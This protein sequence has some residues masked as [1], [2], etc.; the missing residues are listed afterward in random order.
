[1]P[2]R[3]LFALT[4]GLI[5]A[6]I[7][8]GLVVRG[9]SVQAYN[10]HNLI[11]FHIIPNSNAEADQVLKLRVRDAVVRYLTPEVQD[12]QDAREARRIVLRELD[13]IRTVA[14]SEVRAA[15]KDYP[16]QVCFGTYHFP[17]RTYGA[18]QV[19]EGEYQAVRVVIGAGEGRNWWCVLFPPLC[20]MTV[21]ENRTA[22]LAANGEAV[23]VWSESEVQF[24]WRLQEWW[25]KS[26]RFAGII[27]ELLGDREKR[28]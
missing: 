20:F 4:A 2:K 7:V 26:T 24:R 23:P 27:A 3:V 11:R 5:V 28:S 9:P 15:G 16:V 13:A 19:P 14:E 1:M 22:T 17:A 12:I 8:L 21:E 25:E 10:P 6:G 18:L